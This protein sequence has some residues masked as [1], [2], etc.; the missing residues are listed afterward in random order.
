[1][2]RGQFP[3]AVLLYLASTL[4]CQR[5]RDP[6]GDVGVALAVAAWRDLS[7]R[8]NRIASL[9]PWAVAVTDDNGR[10]T[11]L[12]DAILPPRGFCRL[13]EQLPRALDDDRPAR[14]GIQGLGCLALVSIVAVLV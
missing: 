9:L 1:M 2:H 4:L 13:D 8:W 14:G 6:I 7:D 11:L 5:V 10:S 3:W 12:V